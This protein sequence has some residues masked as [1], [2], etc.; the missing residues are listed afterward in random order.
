MR[1]TLVALAAAAGLTG[2][3]SYSPQQISSMS[4]DDLCDLQRYQQMNL[5]AAGKASLEAELQRRKESCS[6]LVAQIDKDH[7]DDEYDRMY[8]RQSP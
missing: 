5:T 4:S 1:T 8:N 2:C 7:A 6:G 3:L